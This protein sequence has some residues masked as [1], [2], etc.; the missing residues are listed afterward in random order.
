VEVV[1]DGQHFLDRA[2]EAV[3]LPDGERVPLAQVAERRGEPGQFADGLPGADLLGVDPAA[4]SGRQ[5]VVLQLGV[6][7][8]GGDA[9]DAD[10]G[11]V[12]DG[13]PST[14]RQPR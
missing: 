13:D 14:W 10:E 12:A 6:L 1:G 11:P 2:A 8:V 4:P 9:G 3:Q 7:G 5:G